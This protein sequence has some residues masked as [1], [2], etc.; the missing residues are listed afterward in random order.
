[1][2]C[3][4]GHKKPLGGLDRVTMA[5]PSFIPNMKQNWGLYV[6]TTNVWDQAQLQQVN[7]NSEEFK[8]LLVR[9][10]QNIND[11]AV[12][13]NYKDSAIYDTQEFVNGQQFFSNTANQPTKLR[14][15]FRLVINTGTLPAGVTSLTHNLPITATWT[16][17]R[18]Y[19]TASDSVGF[20]YYPMPWAGA[21]GAFISLNVNATQVVIN[22]NSGVNFTSGIVVLEYLKN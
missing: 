13:L 18:I 12:A 4:F 20:N 10:Y 1:M 8:L 2:L 17:T 6:P 7:V 14:P 19:G 9:L 22:N 16:F 11:I 3:F 15:D 5:D 21:A